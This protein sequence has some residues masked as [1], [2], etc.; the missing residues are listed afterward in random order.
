LFPHKVPHL[1]K[2]KNG[3][4]TL[5]ELDSVFV[6]RPGFEPG[7]PSRVNTLSKRAP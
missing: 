1:H 5:D 2:K 3:V 6:E 7:L 4:Q